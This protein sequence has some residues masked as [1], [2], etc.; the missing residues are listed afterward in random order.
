MTT[1]ISRLL[2]L[3]I[4]LSSFM[5]HGQ[6]KQI[7]EAFEKYR[8]G[9][10]IE[11]V[12]LHTDKEVYARGETLWFAAYLVE[13]T[14][15]LPSDLS[16]IVHVELLD[17]NDAILSKI[18]LKMAEGTGAGDII[19]GDTLP[20]GEYFI[21]GYSH[22]Q[23]NF[24]PAFIFSK[25]IFLV[26]ATVLK[27]EDQKQASS[28]TY[29]FQYFPEGGDLIVGVVNQVA[30]KGTDDKGMGV[31]VV[32]SIVNSKGNPIVDFKS[33]HHGMGRL[34]FTPEAGK[35]YSFKYTINGN[36]YNKPIK[37]PLEKGA[38]LAVR[39]TNSAFILTGN[40]IGGLNIEDCLVVGHVRG[41]VY[42]LAKP[43]GKEFIYAKV[44]FNRMPNGIIHLTLFYKGDPIQERLVYNENT[45]L[46]PKL[47]FASS[48]QQ[49]RQNTK[50]EITL[51]NQDGSPLAGKI[52]A[53]VLGESIRPNQVTI[54]SY[55]NALSDL[56][57]PI[58]DPAYY[59]DKNNPDR[60][61]HLDLLMLTQ[62]WRRFVWSD[63]L[64]G[65]LTEINY[66]AEKGF[67]IEGKLVDYYKRK[68]SKPGTVALSFMENLLFNE[69]VE[70]DAEGNFYF[71]GLSIQYT[72]TVV[73]Q[74]MRPTKKDKLKRETGA[75]VVIKQSD[76]LSNEVTMLTILD[77]KSDE[78]FAEVLAD[79]EEFVYKTDD[80]IELD[81]FVVTAYR[82][83][84]ED[85]NDPFKR[86]GVL[87]KEP[88]NRMVMDSVVGYENYTN[89]FELISGQFPGVRITGSGLERNAL[90][91]GG[92]PL[93][94]KASFL[95]D[96]TEVDAAFINNLDPRQIE[97]I[98]IIRGNSAAVL[99]GT[100][101]GIIAIYSKRGFI[102]E[103]E[104][105][106]RGM[107]AF[108]HPGYYQAREFYTPNYD[109][110]TIEE[111][112]AKD[113][114]TTQYWSSIRTIENGKVTLEYTA[115][116]DLGYFVLYVEGITAE[117]ESFSAQ[118]EFEMEDF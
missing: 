33:A 105:D 49:R 29:D 51:L 25:S 69:E 9:N 84:V 115:S 57:G 77:R 101:G 79:V 72:V 37:S 98:D 6:E 34:L 16:E 17:V 30:I 53:S 38:K 61:Q 28:E 89:V 52:S 12:Y 85:S 75:Y 96:G 21:R 68:K 31:D 93:T 46:L 108:R 107:I 60:M 11:K 92:D 71:D 35:T 45:E 110:M 7:L 80:V 113:L 63:L 83:K 50:L 2:L 62:G 23:R 59:F 118:Y 86:P 41:Q 56:K 111:A 100:Q 102:P 78:Q 32:G 43:E 99:Y 20:V 48:N 114:R 91:R 47:Q 54:N 88:D 13:G 82:S 15:H 87:Y 8:S 94:S 67:S 109:E 76:S 5:A 95:Y 4:G 27:E 106:P 44:P 26:D 103:K 14:N 116:D 3:A 112:L 73:V 90:I 97:F 36:E 24:D 18:S 70:T 64:D 1:L 65:Q 39:L 22:Y 117:G 10:P 66:F 42:L 104:E 55:L 19:L 74:A 58:Q 81:E 40:V